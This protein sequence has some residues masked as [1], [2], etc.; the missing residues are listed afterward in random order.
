M[1]PLFVGVDVA[2]AENTWLACLAKDGPCVRLEQEPRKTS[3]GEIVQLAEQRDVVA[4][5]ID[6]QLSIAVS[7]ENGFRSSDIEL[8]ALLP[9]EF[10][11]WVASVNAL[12]AVP[13]RARLL[14][15]A[16]SPSVGTILETHPRAALYFGSSAELDDALR[17][18]KKGPE[19]TALVQRLWQAWSTRFGIDG[20]LGIL[21][22]GALDA[23]VCATVAYLAHHRPEDLLRLRHGAADKTGRGPFYVV[24]PELRQSRA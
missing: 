7:D 20:D 3:L 8:R 18:Y 14:S 23:A 22:D 10:R 4:V 11:T 15:D 9:A 16:L 17:H 5:A 1:L 24:R 21:S 19:P 13:I 2:G 6:A 12:M